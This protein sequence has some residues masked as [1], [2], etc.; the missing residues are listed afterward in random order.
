MVLEFPERDELQSI[1][2]VIVT[3]TIT[4]PKL[5]DTP[6]LYER[7]INSTLDVTVTPPEIADTVYVVNVGSSDATVLLGGARFTVAPGRRLLVSGLALSSVGVRGWV[8]L[9]FARKV[10][11]RY[12]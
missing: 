9:Y 10:V 7:E 11:I 8:R 3:E 5:P 2:P 12:E 6:F 1:E 4:E